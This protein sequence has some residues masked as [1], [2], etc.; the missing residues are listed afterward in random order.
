MVSNKYSF[1]QLEEVPMKH[2]IL[3]LLLVISVPLVWAEPQTATEDG[4]EVTATPLP[5]EIKGFKTFEVTL[6]SSRSSDHSVEAEIW[7]NDN[8]VKE[9]GGAR[10]KCS[11]MVGLKGGTTVTEKKHCKEEAPSNSF[12]VRIKKVFSKIF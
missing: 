6:K 2:T 10:G 5:D 9:P 4:I 12:T 7:L 8:T 11:V 1:L 3:T